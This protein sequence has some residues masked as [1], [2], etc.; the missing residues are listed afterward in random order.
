VSDKPERDPEDIRVGATIKALREAHGLTAV[1]LG[2]AV[3]K[4]EQL[5]HA[6]ENGSRHA[7]PQVCRRIV[8]TLGIPLAAITVAN[9]EEI[10]DGER[11]A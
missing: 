7:T 10:R 2:R 5:I 8:D 3:G 11:V 6:V 1:E 9:Y 4:S